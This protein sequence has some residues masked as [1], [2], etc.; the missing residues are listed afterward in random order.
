M[1]KIFEHYGLVAL[2]LFMHYVS[3]VC[4]EYIQIYV[5]KTIHKTAKKRLLGNGLPS[6]IMQIMALLMHVYCFLVANEP[7]KNAICD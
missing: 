7:S 5:T 4:D 2:I 1:L 3:P 6:A